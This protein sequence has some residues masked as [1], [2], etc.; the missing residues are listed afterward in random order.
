MSD[1]PKAKAF[2]QAFHDFRKEDRSD[3]Y[4]FCTE[5]PSMTRQEFAEECDINSIMSRYDSYLADP[6]RSIREPSYVDFTVM[7]ST[8]MGA[9]DAFKAAEAA[10]MTL[11]AQVR[12]EFDN[13]PAMFADFASEP[14]NVDQMRDWGLAKPLPEAP[15]PPEP[16][17]V[18]VVA[19]PPKP[20]PGG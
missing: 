10:F 18:R 16:V 14:T 4:E 7:P 12:R 2:P 8:L 13:D 17:E 3:L 6:M 15:K 9:M 5:G 11:P 19:D 1:A 20:P